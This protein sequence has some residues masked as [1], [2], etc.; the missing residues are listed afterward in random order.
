M[1]TF[2]SD[3]PFP[4]S[5]VPSSPPLPI[6]LFFLCYCLTTFTECCATLSK[7]L[8]QMSLFNLQGNSVK[9]G[10]ILISPGMICPRWRHR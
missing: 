4:P 10:A 2:L 3:I 9:Q 1:A 7:D 8:M 5:P 6:L